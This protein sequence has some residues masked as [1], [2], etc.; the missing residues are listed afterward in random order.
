MTVVL[1]TRVDDEL[2]DWVRSYAKARDVTVQLWLEAAARAYRVDCERSV[3]DIEAAA[4]VAAAKAKVE[5]TQRPDPGPAFADPSGSRQQ[6]LNAS[7]LRAR[8]VKR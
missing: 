5:A 6:R 3:P 4:R 2:G 7:M 8:G 1:S